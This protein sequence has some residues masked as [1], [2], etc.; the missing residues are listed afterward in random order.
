MNIIKEMKLTYSK[1]NA[2]L[3]SFITKCP[4]CGTY[5]NYIKYSHINKNGFWEYKIICKNCSKPIGD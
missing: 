3:R 5:D 1:L 4:N 2:E